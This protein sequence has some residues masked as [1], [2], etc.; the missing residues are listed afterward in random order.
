MTSFAARFT[1]Q[2]DPLCLHHFNLRSLYFQ[3]LPNWIQLH[4]SGSSAICTPFQWINN[5]TFFCYSLLLGQFQ[6]ELIYCGKGRQNFASNVT[7]YPCE[8]SRQN[9]LVV[10]YK[11]VV[12]DG[13][14]ERTR[15]TN[16]TI[17]HLKLSITHTKACCNLFWY[18]LKPALLTC[19]TLVDHNLVPLRLTREKPILFYVGLS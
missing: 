19:H 15:A 6:L 14:L 17:L 13:W 12:E 1:S 3:S 18:G 10:Y 8:R 2:S 11:I 16:Q 5:N 7:L 4:T 9:H